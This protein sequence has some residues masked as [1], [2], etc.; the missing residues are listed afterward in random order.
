MN[1]RHIQLF[2]NLKNLVAT[3]EAF[4]TKIH[5]FEGARYQVFDYFLARYS[6]FLL[7]DSR[8]ARGIMF[9]VDEAGNPI[10]LACWMPK[11]FF[12]LNEN[13]FTIGLD[14]SDDNIDGVMD[15]MDG[16]IISTMMHNG[17]MILKS[18]T[19]LS[20]DHAAQATAFLYKGGYKSP[21]A[22]HLEHYT[23]AGYSVHMEL[24]SPDLRI[25][26]GYPEIKLT[27][28]SMRRLSDGAMVNRRTFYDHFPCEFRDGYDLS[29]WVA[30]F[31]PEY[32][33]NTDPFK[34]KGSFGIKFNQMTRNAN[35]DQVSKFIDSIKGMTGVEGYIVRLK[36]GEHIKIKCD[37]Y[38]ALHHTKDSI[39]AP[40]RLF[41]TILNGAA[42][43]LKAMF[44]ADPITVGRVVEMENKVVEKFN[45]LI[46]KVETFYNE[47]KSLDRKAYAIA[48]TAERDDN[49]MGP[50]M[51]LYL[52]KENNYKEFFLKH[53]EMFDVNPTEESN[54]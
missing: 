34:Q 51:N 35:G 28:L 17:K 43:D 41:E 8:E 24:T 22:E 23:K 11:K 36:N 5:E 49:L 6:D 47:H 30:D 20:S 31:S 21:L 52:G 27:I 39:S 50:K 19:S 53:P 25:V 13:P 29:Y 3:N 33:N 42:D 38:C 12:N 48:A 46:K 4:V 9:E 40:R 37:W 1:D 32:F 16:S 10:R 18:K 44:A 45:R 54:D 15:K 7:E 2:A 26:L 14:L